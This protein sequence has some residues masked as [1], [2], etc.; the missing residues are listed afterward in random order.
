VAPAGMT[1]RL[2]FWKTYVA[3]AVAAALVGYALLVERKREDKPAEK[4]KEKV[5]TLDKSKVE[6]LELAHAGGEDV[7]VVKEGGAWRLA[8]P[9]EA[10][11]DAGEV[12]SV[13]SSL[14]SL[15]IQDVVAENPADVTEFGLSSPKTKVSVRLQGASE[16]AKLLVGDK[17]PDG[18]A[19]Y[20]KTAARPRVFTIP[21]FLE[22]TFGKKAFDLRDRD[23]L[24]VKRDAVKTVEVTGPEASYTLVRDDRGEWSFTKPVRTRAGR[25][26]VDGL[27]GTV[28]GLRFDT[29]AKEKATPADLKTFGLAAPA[30]TV[31][32]GL[33]DGGTKTLE[34]GGKAGGKDEKK[35][36]AREARS[37]LVAVI[38]GTLVDDLGKGM[39]ELRAK[40][41]L[42]VATYEVQ[43]IEVTQGSAKKTYARSSSKDKEGVD[44][45][46]W[47]RTAP[48][49]KDLDT[50][51]VQDALYLL[52]G[53]EAQQFVDAPKDPAAYG[54]DQPVLKVSLT[55]EAG[56]RPPVWFELGRKE[57]AV[58][59]RRADDAA[60]LK[61]DTAK[62]EEIIKSFG[63][64]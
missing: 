45:Y 42:D 19:L 60:I 31:T 48:D 17:T 41:L 44:S 5:F 14:E 43:G 59:A 33:G 47:K 53:A 11:A 24:H 61:L 8:A 38:P 25:W 32:L 51:T 12:D 58:Y 64:L 50:N 46:K 21:G 10:P 9:M 57:G 49:S 36:Y 30:R 56:S 52:S 34:I 23:L 7:K 4:P 3:A 40:R 6:A 15:E 63:N 55:Y 28:E 26:S 13:V 35:Y 20:A 16:P 2:P 37:P 22:T 54:L 18:G 27:L 39:G 1:S 62:G 29:V